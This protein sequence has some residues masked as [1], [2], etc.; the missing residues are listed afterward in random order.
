MESNHQLTFNIL[1]FNHAKP[2]YTLH[3][4]GTEQAGLHRV[5]KNLVPDEVIK[6]FGQ[7]EHYYT[8]FN[9]PF[10]GSLSVTKDSTPT[11]N[12]VTDESGAEREVYN[13]S[14]CFTRSILKR[15]YNYSIQEYFRSEGHLVKPNFVDDIEVWL[16]APEPAPSDP[17]NYY[18]RYTLRV[19]FATVTKQPELLLTYAGRPKSFK[20]SVEDLLPDVSV[21]AFKWVIY[22]HSLYR[23]E[24]LPDEA[25]RR[26]HEV[27][28]VWN[29]TLRVE[30]QHDKEAPE[31]GHRYFKFKTKLNDFIRNH[32]SL[33]GLMEIIPL[34]TETFIKVK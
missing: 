13:F 25:R 11:I 33:N 3:F 32:L 2:A 5:H 26:L 34:Q 7:Q 28:P 17:Y 21:D 29:F 22:N 16:P 4:S 8:S 15:F 31:W 27:Y 23:Y 10:E 24:E 6:H 1:T 14:N 9:Q 20:L 19:Q 18:E 30:L 12:T